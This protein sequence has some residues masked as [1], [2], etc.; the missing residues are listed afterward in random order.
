MQVGEHSL[1]RICRPRQRR[2]RRSRRRSPSCAADSHSGARD[3][4][5]DRPSSQTIGT[6]PTKSLELLLELRRQNWP[7]GPAPLTM[8]TCMVWGSTCRMSSMIRGRSLIAAA[9]TSFSPSGSLPRYRWSTAATGTDVR[10]Q[11]RPVSARE[12]ERRAPDRHDQIR[13][14]TIH[15]GGSD[16]IDDRLFRR[17]DESRRPH[18]DLTEIDRAPDPLIHLD[19]EVGG[20]VIE[21]QV[22]ALDRLQHQHLA[23]RRAQPRSTPPRAASNQ[24]AQRFEIR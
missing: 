19:A 6:R 13:L 23:S 16:E 18:I 4:Q 14:G 15:V 9:A 1:V 21:N 5:A 2:C 3:P 11:P 20:E 8:N 12:G 22:A 10:K 7:C 17:G 24:L